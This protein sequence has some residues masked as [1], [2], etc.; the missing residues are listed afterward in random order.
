MTVVSNKAKK[1]E[2]HCRDSNVSK[3]RKFNWFLNCFFGQYSVSCCK[4][5][6][7]T[8][9][10]TVYWNIHWVCIGVTGMDFWYTMSSDIACK[11]QL[12]KITELC[13]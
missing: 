7:E 1:K 11:S 9:P 3:S 13:G 8:Q 12:P 5:G 2:V 4:G 6:F 10:M